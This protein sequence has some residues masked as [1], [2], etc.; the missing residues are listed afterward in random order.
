MHP[1]VW[2]EYGHEI[3][4]DRTINTLRLVSE[5]NSTDSTRLGIKK[6][7]IWKVDEENKYIYPILHNQIKLGNNVL[8][9]LLYYGNEYIEKS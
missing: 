4:E 9:N 3:G 2:L 5:S 8:Y 1:K 7:P 6:S